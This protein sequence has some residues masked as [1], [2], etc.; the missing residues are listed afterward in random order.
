M[1]NTSGFV[2]GLVLTAIAQGAFAGL[3]PAQ[4]TVLITGANRGIGL[5]FAR[6]YAARNWNVIATARNPADALELAALSK[7]DPDVVVERLD[8]TDH[9]GIDVLAAKYADQPIDLLLSNAGKTPRYMSAFK[10]AKGVDFQMARD[11]YEINALGPLK[12]IGAFQPHV[13]KSKA[14]KI[15]VVSSKAG[16]FGE[17][18]KAAMMYEYRTSKAALNMIVHTA[19]FETARQGITLVALS[20]GS[21]NTEA[22]KGELGY[23]TPIRQPGAISTGDSVGGML[24][25]IDSLTTAQN[26]KF[27]DYKDGREIPW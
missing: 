8:V 27:L 18:P 23:G 6:Q 9:P 10:Q 22:V 5:E 19:S 2:A 25:V 12:L 17:G 26:G 4:P 24:K 14:K 16:S 1:R 3:N 13:A 11:S 15:V 21:V 20:P 7:S